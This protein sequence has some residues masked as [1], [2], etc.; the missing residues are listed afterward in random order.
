MFKSVKLPIRYHNTLLPP[1]VYAVAY[2]TSKGPTAQFP[3]ARLAIHTKLAQK[4][5]LAKAAYWLI[6]YDS[7]EDLYRVISTLE[8]KEGYA[9]RSQSSFWL[10]IKTLIS[11]G[12]MLPLSSKIIII[13]DFK[14]C[15]SG[16]TF[17]I[18]VKI[19]S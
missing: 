10:A 2:W 12:V 9:V 3:T 6:E 1:D 13:E 4:C 14:I 8:W 19:G 11:P 18:P 15:G 16:I 7:D 5:G 17:P